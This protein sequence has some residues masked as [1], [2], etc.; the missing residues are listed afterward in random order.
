MY[1]PFYPFTIQLLEGFVAKGKKYFVRQTF[2]RAFDQFDENIEGYYFF[3]HYDNLMRA[4][5]HFEAIAHD[6]NRFL[7][8][9][10]NPEHQERLRKAASNLFKEYKVYAAVA[11]PNWERGLTNRLEQKVRA[12]VSRLG[13]SPKVEDLVETKFEIKYGELMLILK[14]RN[15]KTKASFSEIENISLNDALINGNKKP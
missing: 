1:N 14:Y 15:R 3:T 5:E 6:P 8:D 11:K 4:R 9:W 2:D 7:Y 10:D 12:H 13:W